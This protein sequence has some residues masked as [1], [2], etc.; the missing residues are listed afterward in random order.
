VSALWGLL[1]WKEFAGATR[2][3]RALLGATLAL[4][5]AALALILLAP[6]FTA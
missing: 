5:A 2:R 6:P 3:V 4:F 1:V